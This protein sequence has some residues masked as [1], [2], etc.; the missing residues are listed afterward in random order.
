VH[1]RKAF[2]MLIAAALP[3]ASVS[4]VDSTAQARGAPTATGST[5]CRLA[6]TINS[7]VPLTRGGT[8]G[9]KNDVTTIDLSTVGS[10]TGGSG[11]P[12]AITLKAIKVTLPKVVP[13]GTCAGGPM[14]GSSST[15]KGKVTWA[16]VKP[17]KLTIN[18]LR[19]SVNT[20][21]EVGFTAHPVVT[22]SFARTGTI[23]VYITQADTS[24]SA[25][26]SAGLSTV[27]IDPSTSSATL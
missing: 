5:T 14:W 16:S 3:L 12:A 11:S 25:S 19:S 2:V 20:A 24:A 13:A 9:T 22:G 17:S 18:G 7:S 21:G 15:V 23:V 4:L 10:C 27:N 6:G 8:P 26:C 1:L